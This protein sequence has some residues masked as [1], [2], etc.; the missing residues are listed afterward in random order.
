MYVCASLPCIVWWCE[1]LKDI[2]TA[3][4]TFF[5]KLLIY[6]WEFFK[7]HKTFLAYSEGFFLLPVSFTNINNAHTIQLRLQ[8][9]LNRLQSYSVVLA[10]IGVV[11]WKCI[12]G[13]GKVHTINCHSPICDLLK[14]VQVFVVCR[15]WAYGSASLTLHSKFWVNRDSEL[16][17]GTVRLS[18][19]L[20]KPPTAMI[21]PRAK[22]SPSCLWMSLKYWF[23]NIERDF[24]QPP[25]RTEAI[26]LYFH[27]SLEE[28]LSLISCACTW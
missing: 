17:G 22:M 6:A 25:F 2:I 12:L 19:V 1:V 3:W 14:Q 10:T 11:I 18:D 27:R 28:P 21:G 20:I 26:G 7:I 16:P 9:T 15:D 4:K 23:A 24:Q 8:S 5:P 13:R